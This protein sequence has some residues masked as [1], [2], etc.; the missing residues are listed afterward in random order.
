MRPEPISK[1][2]AASRNPTL[3]R[4]VAGVLAAGA[5]LTGAAG[6]IGAAIVLTAGPASA[7][8]A[9]DCAAVRARDHQIY[10]NLIASLPPGS[11]IPPEYINPCLT[12][13]STTTT[14]QPTSTA[15]LPGAQA[16]G[17]GPNV[18]ANAPTNFPTY[19]GTPI[20]PGPGPVPV[21]GVVQTATPGAPAAPGGESP[22]GVPAAT[23]TSGGAPTSPQ[24]AGSTAPTAVPDRG[25]GPIPTDTDSDTAPAQPVPDAG[26]PTAGFGQGDGRDRYLELVLVGA[27][28]FTAG[29]IG[30]RGRRSPFGAR[31]PESVLSQAVGTVASPLMQYD[32]GGQSKITVPDPGGGRRTLFLIHDRSSSHESVIPVD[33]P[34]GGRMSVDPDG[35]VTVVDADG[36]PV[37]TVA[38]P[39]AY[40]AD[41]TPIPTHFEIRDG[42]LVQVVDTVGIENILYPIL[43]DPPSGG[44]NIATG[45]EMTAIPLYNGQ[46]AISGQPGGIAVVGDPDPGYSPYQPTTDTVKDGTD[47]TVDQGNGTTN[48]YTGTG[49]GTDAGLPYT[50]EATTDTYQQMAADQAAAEQAA[51]D[52]AARLESAQA[53]PVSESGIEPGDLEGRAS[54]VD[55]VWAWTYTDPDGLTR[56]LQVTY[57]DDGRPWRVFDH[58]TGNLYLYDWSTGEPVLRQS[59]HLDS[60]SVVDQTPELM[61]LI[62]PP[63]R[64]TRAISGALRLDDLIISAK[65]P[66][67]PNLGPGTSTRPRDRPVPA[68]DPTGIPMDPT[69]GDPA[70]I[71]PAP[72]ETD[73]VVPDPEAPGAPRRPGLDDFDP[74]ALDPTDL[75]DPTALDDPTDLPTV[76]A[77]PTSSTPAAPTSPPESSYAPKLG[78]GESAPN[79]IDVPGHGTL[80]I[81]ALARPEIGD[82]DLGNYP[83]LGEPRLW[84]PAGEGPR[85]TPDGR[86]KDYR[87]IQEL[88]TGIDGDVAYTINGVKFDGWFPDDGI[89]TEIKGNFAFL[90]DSA[91]NPTTWGADIWQVKWRDQ[92]QAQARALDTTGQNIEHIWVMLQ[93]NTI[94]LAE[95]VFSANGLENIDVLSLADWLERIRR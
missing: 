26:A 87:V 74:Y 43:A 21:P 77:P 46:D 83:D 20:V 42:H 69:S 40:D 29:G 50:T 10:L 65:P 86:L 17:G 35:S 63:L 54:E 18:G 82:P 22:A 45:R 55:N 75:D 48:R 32:K 27:A 34:P 88:A 44:E 58:A 28:A 19:N 1:P 6:V 4:S 59:Q 61:S 37:S 24:P 90:F 31:T 38:A 73:R 80:D 49:T 11:P 89:V 95:R 52:A 92:A 68:L 91:G 79:F 8:P 57:D 12:A 81:G 60:G 62:V 84:A 9:E 76:T 93:E 67:R 13:P 15:G 94:D 5:L 51:D 66:T 47:L 3:R 53:P 30:V 2:I 72:T 33:V 78:D 25:P 56:N 70:A 14:A 39:W 7:G 85:Y 71:T 16:P 23:A 36:N 41:G 64:G